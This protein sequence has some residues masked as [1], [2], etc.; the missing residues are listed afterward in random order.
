MSEYNKTDLAGGETHSTPIQWKTIEVIVFS[1]TF[2][3]E[4]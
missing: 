2:L 4:S 1:N 3:W